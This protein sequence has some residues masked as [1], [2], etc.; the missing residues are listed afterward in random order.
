MQDSF[1][2]AKYCIAMMVAVHGKYSP[3]DDDQSEEHLKVKDRDLY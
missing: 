3:I 2:L 1:S